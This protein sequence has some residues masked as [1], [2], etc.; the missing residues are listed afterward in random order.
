MINLKNKKLECAIDIGTNKTI[1]IIYQVENNNFNIVGWNQ[2]KSN[3]VVR[4]KVLD[5]DGVSDTITDILKDI[6]YKKNINE[7]ILS[8]ITDINLTSKKSYSEIFL[9]GLGISKKEIRR[10]YKKNIQN[11]NLLQ[12]KLI[13]SIPSKFT[14][15]DNLIVSNPIGKQCDRLALTTFNIWVGK[16]VFNNLENVYKN[17]KLI[18]DETIDSA[19]AS[20]VSC[21]EENNTLGTV[22]IDI[23]GGS[24]KIATYFNG[25]LEYVNYIPLGGN[26]VTNDIENGLEIS[27]ELAEYIKVI[28][29]DLEFSSNKK[30][31]IDMSN[32]SNKTIT[33][34]LLH[35]IIKP[36]YEEIF[37][38]IRDKL[39][40]NLIT[41]MGINKIILT[42]GVSQA[43]G[44]KRLSEKIFNR[45]TNIV[46]PKTDLKGL[47][48]RPEFSTVFGLMKIK[49][50]PKLR[51]I[52]KL[53]TNNKISNVIEKF[54]T[55]I[56]ES[57]M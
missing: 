4:S 38:I 10:L 9:G 57:F 3:G 19:F 27:K 48:N 33:Q 51:K 17:S 56:K 39:D 46:F 26:D 41:K 31:N 5:A 21:I 43:N 22:Y 7:R 36:R 6:S 50:N 8:S 23:G 1:C 34:N 49:A 16:E 30:I 11:S 37:E 29:G 35:G 32:G 14:I 28:H 15:D 2:K 52:M 42:G 47:K 55:W 44:L 54:D 45:E 13:H 12:R 40:D 18:L 25:C 24:S 20:S 53:Q